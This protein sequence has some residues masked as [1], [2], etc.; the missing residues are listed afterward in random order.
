MSNEACPHKGRLGF[1]EHSQQLTGWQIAF[2]PFLGNRH[3]N[4]PN[5]PKSK[6]CPVWANKTRSNLLPY[7]D[8]LPI[9][10][11]LSLISML[12]DRD[13]ATGTMVVWQIETSV[14]KGAMQK[15]TG[16]FW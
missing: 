2:T 8:A 3:A 12:L 11:F 10:V 7:A 9:V 4:F 1:I 5:Q 14:Q 15:F 13:K 16:W 6:A